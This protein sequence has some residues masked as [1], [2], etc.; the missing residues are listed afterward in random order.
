MTE[1][2]KLLSQRR[3]ELFRP[4]TKQKDFFAAGRTY[5][6]RL[7]RAGN[8]LG[9]SFAGGAEAAYHL[10]GQYPDWW[11]GRVF[12]RPVAA[13]AGAPTGETARD[14]PQRV[15]LGRPGQH[16]TGMIP[17]ANIIEVVAARGVADLADYV[18]VRHPKG[19]SVIKFKT[20]DQGRIK[21]QGDTLDFV[22]FDEEPPLDIYTEGITRTNATKGFCYLTFTPLL[23]MSE[24][25]RRFLVENN[26]DRHDTNMVIEDAEHIEP[27]ERQRII[28]SYPAHEREARTKGVP[29]M[30]SGLIF[31]VADSQITVKAFEIPDHWA[32]IGSLDFGWDHPTAAVRLAH[33]RDNDIV[34]VMAAYRVREAT[35][36]IHSA[37][38]R[39]WGDWLPWAWPHDGL[40]HSKDSGKPLAEQYRINGLRM[41]SE[42]AKYPPNDDG[43]AGQSGVE[44]GLMDMLMRMQTGRLKVFEHLNDWFEEKRLYHRQDGKVIKEYDDLMSATRYGIMSLRY[45]ITNP[46]YL[47]P[48][49]RHRYGRGRAA[50]QSWMGA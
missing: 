15:L 17:A 1:A 35:P 40:Q 45:A 44:A 20:Y 27:A 43:T 50:Q 31:P 25:V 19:E 29:I 5:R 26:P 47:P 21:W 8:Q 3:L 42:H 39:S 46:D 32:Q 41:L 12:D 48:E 6:E 23:G 28:D 10:T 24:V 22:W 4:Y 2:E 16:G 36:L 14:N 11:T 34:Y 30:G 38:L 7:L 13:W 18:R 49:V 33:D 37:A 9:K